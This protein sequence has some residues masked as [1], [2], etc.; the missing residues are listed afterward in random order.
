[1]QKVMIVDDNH[2]NRLVASGFLEDDYELLVLESGEACLAKLS[3]F[4]PDVILLD[5]MMPGLD[6][7]EVLQRIREDTNRF[8]HVSEP[9]N[10]SKNLRKL[11]ENFAN[12]A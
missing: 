5:W 6:G 4:I 2:Q 11:R 10:T 8:K 12:I 7:L 1:M 9:T 3:E